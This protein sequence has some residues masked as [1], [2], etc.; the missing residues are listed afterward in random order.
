MKYVQNVTDIDD[1]VLRKARELG[2]EWDELGRR[3]TERFLR[4][5]ETLNVRMPDV[6]AKATDHIGEIIEI[7][8]TLIERGNAYESEGCVYYSVKSDPG[9]GEL[10]RAIGLEDYHALL[11]IA[12]ERGNFPDDKRKR[13]PL[14]HSV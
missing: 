7:N 8:R 10:G 5:L 6:Y 14:G 13:D 2:M 12:N 9:F 11:T 4:D 3:E 1:D